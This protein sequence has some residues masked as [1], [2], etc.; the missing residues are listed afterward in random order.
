M[1]TISKAGVGA[2][3]A[4]GQ[5]ANGKPCLP[6]LKVRLPLANQEAS[7]A[8][9]E[10]VIADDTPMSEVERADYQRMM[11]TLKSMGVE[12]ARTILEIRRRKLYREEF[13]TFDEWV[14]CYFGKTRQWVTGLGN[15]VRRQEL[16]ESLAKEGP[17]ALPY[18]GKPAYQ[19][20][21]KEAEALGPL[22]DHPEELCRAL[23]EAT[24]MCRANPK[25]K[26]TKALEQAV[27]KQERYLR[28]RESTPDL[29]YEEFEAIDSMGWSGRLCGS[30]ISEINTMKA[31]G[32]NWIDKAVA[33]INNGNFSGEVL[34]GWLRGQELID[35]CA[36]LKSQ[37]EVR[38]RLKEA[39]RQAQ[40]AAA[41]LEWTKADITKGRE[42]AAQPHEGESDAQIAASE[43]KDGDD[44]QEDVDHHADQQKVVQATLPEFE[45]ELTGSFDGI[46]E[47]LHDSIRKL[48]EGWRL[49]VWGWNL[50]ATSAIV[51]K[52]D[53]EDE[54][55]Q[56]VFA[57]DM[58]VR[59]KRILQ[60]VHDL[61]D[62]DLSG[63]I[64]ACKKAKDLLPKANTEQEVAA[65]G[66]H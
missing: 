66:S 13:K 41:E 22:E 21:P 49:N 35:L 52:P 26:R 61:T 47:G 12:M 58:L 37:I 51:V 24:E 6:K 64:L 4:L 39:E 45:V 23:V 17:L 42:A 65:S 53:G 7:E 5:L 1:T 28:R 18:D 56:L 55:A 15:W 60:R 34:L 16:L 29:T 44:D 3:Q 10:L 9:A 59:V 40:E 30:G 19:I 2:R 20:M 62:M 32:G 57:R 11:S 33:E 48:L 14:A 36:K 43:S 27:E 38:D 8:T 54:A 31:D 63:S 25:R 50:T 46:P